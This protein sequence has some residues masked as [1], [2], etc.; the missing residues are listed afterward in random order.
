MMQ[1]A[2]PKHP[3][4]VRNGCLVG[5]SKSG[6]VWCCI[7]CGV[8]G[9]TGGLKQIYRHNAEEAAERHVCDGSPTR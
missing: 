5:R 9:I 8:G 1:T 6:Y 7:K 2:R 3:D 4:T